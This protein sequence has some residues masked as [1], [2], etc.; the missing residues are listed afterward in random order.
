VKLTQYTVPSL[1]VTDLETT[2][3]GG[4]L[5]QIEVDIRKDPAKYRQGDEFRLYKDFKQYW[6]LGA[7]YHLRKKNLSMASKAVI[8]LQMK[9]N[10]VRNFR[11]SNP[12]A[13][14]RLSVIIDHLFQDLMEA[15]AEIG[16]IDSFSVR[17]DTLKKRDPKLAGIHSLKIIRFH[18]GIFLNGRNWDKLL[19]HEE[20][21]QFD[22]GLFCRFKLARQI[23]YE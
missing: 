17:L 13:V 5:A 22:R 19:A 6:N 8:L 12:L 10:L 20:A 7:K 1:S 18:K 16:E 2:G 11:E 14:E 4:T 3:D 15:R 23:V 9:R 21:G